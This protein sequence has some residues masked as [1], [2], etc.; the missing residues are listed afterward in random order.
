M[1]CPK[2][3]VLIFDVRDELSV[4]ESLIFKGERVLVPK[5][6]RNDMI[7]RV[8]STH[9]G[10]EGCLRRARECF[11]WPGMN[12]EIKNSISCCDV[13][14]SCDTKQ[15]KET[16]YPH[17]VPDRPWVKVAVDLFEFN[18]RNYLITVDYYS[19]RILGGRSF[20]EYQ[21]KSCD[22]QDE[23]AICKIWDS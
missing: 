23:N 20:R 2:K 3:H 21:N 7:K 10:V 19:C 18:S 22:S 5:L 17:E 4:Q 14:R 15:A 1:K 12:A 13:C 8:H 11:Y 6:L 9:L 16:L